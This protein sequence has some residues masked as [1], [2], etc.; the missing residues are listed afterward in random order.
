MDGGERSFTEKPDRRAHGSPAT[1]ADKVGTS[2]VSE[3]DSRCSNA[4]GGEGTAP[5]GFLLTLRPQF[6]PKKNIQIPTEEF[7]VSEQ[8]PT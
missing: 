5:E 7:Q 1:V 2:V 4:V 8:I 3:A 6:S